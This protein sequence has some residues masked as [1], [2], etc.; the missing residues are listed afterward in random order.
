MDATDRRIIREL[1][2]DGRL[3]NQDLAERVNL[4]PSPCLRRLRN[5]ETEGVISGYTALVDQ[6][7]YGLPIT[8]FIRVRLERHAEETVKGFEDRVSRLDEVL[9]C[10]LLAG[11]DD[12]LLR[13]IVASL[14]AYETF[15]RRRLHAIP[16]I[17]SID[18][19]FAYGR[20]KQ[21]RVYPV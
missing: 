21:T 9:D 5:L 1:Q 6:K 19:S 11:S 7:A 14:E 15:V 12:Y 10:Y 20:V 3:S 2:K 8:V 16:G 13:I 18:T 4:S 17:A